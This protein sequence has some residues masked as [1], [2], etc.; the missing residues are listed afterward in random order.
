MDRTIDKMPCHVI[1]FV[2]SSILKRKKKNQ[3]YEQCRERKWRKSKSICKKKEH[4]LYESIWIV[5]KHYNAQWHNMR[6]SAEKRKIFAKK[7]NAHMNSDTIPDL[8]AFESDK[9]LVKVQKRNNI[10]GEKNRDIHMN[11][12][13]NSD[14]IYH[15]LLFE[16]WHDPK[17]SAKKEKYFPRNKK[18]PTV[19]WHNLN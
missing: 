11:R 13:M 6:E 9:I 7:I 10:C 2:N 18:M 1:S 16:H 15:L 4:C 17:E 12:T 14:T 19:H 5:R 3:S 8:I